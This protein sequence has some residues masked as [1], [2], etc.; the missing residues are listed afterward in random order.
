[1]RGPSHESMSIVNK[2]VNKLWNIGGCIDDNL[3]I[4]YIDNGSARLFWQIVQ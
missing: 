4:L 1:M 3:L 2:V